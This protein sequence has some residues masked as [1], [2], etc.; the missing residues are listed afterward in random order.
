MN[1][2][3]KLLAVAWA[4]VSEVGFS[5]ALKIIDEVRSEIEKAQWAG[6]GSR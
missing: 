3:A 6:H 4:I 5:Q 2:K 1:F